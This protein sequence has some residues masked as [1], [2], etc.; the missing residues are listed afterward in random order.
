MLNN[1]FFTYLRIYTNHVLSI[2]GIHTTELVNLK[3]DEI[4]V[5]EDSIREPSASFARQA[6]SSQSSSNS[7]RDDTSY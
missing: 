1:V 2:L 5:G 3:L 7:G 6:S 4:A